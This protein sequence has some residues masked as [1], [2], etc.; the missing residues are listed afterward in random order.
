MNDA[1][2]NA[3]DETAAFLVHAERSASP[4]LIPGAFEKRA[5]RPASQLPSRPD[6]VTDHAHRVV[7]PSRQ[8]LEHEREGGGAPGARRGT[9]P[10]TLGVRLWRSLLHPTR[11]P[12][13]WR[14]VLPQTS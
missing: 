1:R 5:A 14:R 12:D 3:A 8:R 6:V 9:R 10:G 4:V 13:I 11:V 7:A 2:P